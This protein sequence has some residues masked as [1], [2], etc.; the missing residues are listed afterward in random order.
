M[1]D[2]YL[3]T[4]GK[5]TVHVSA[6]TPEELNELAPAAKALYENILKCYGNKAQMW[7][8]AMKAN[9]QLPPLRGQRPAS[10]VDTDA[11]LCPV[12]GKPM[13]QRQGKFGSFWS[14]NQKEPNGKWCTVTKQSGVE[15]KM[16]TKIVEQ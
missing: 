11:P 14:C 2:L 10:P 4:D 6:N 13:R 5:S 9:A 16:P 7:E 12:H 1:I 15:E 3:S 8:A